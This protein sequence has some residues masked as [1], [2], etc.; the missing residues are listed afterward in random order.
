[1]PTLLRKVALLVGVALLGL[2]TFAATYYVAAT[3]ADT[4]N[5][6]SKATPWLH[7]PGMST[8]TSLCSSTTIN[9]GDSIIFRGGDTWHFGDNTQVPFAGFQ[10]N[11][12]AF[13]RSGSSTSCQLNAAAGA[14]VTTTCIYIG[15]DQTWFA[16]G[17]WTR[18]VFNF[19]NPVTTTSPASCTFDDTTLNPIHFNASY[20]IV[21]NLEIFGFCSNSTTTFSNLIAFSNGNLQWEWKNS[22][23]HGYMLGQTCTS[24]GGADCDEYWVFGGFT[25]ISSYYRIDH[26]VFDNSDGTYGGSGNKASLGVWN[27]GGMQF[28]HNVLNYVSNGLKF[29]AMLMV[30]DNLFNNIFEPVVGG[31]HGNIIEYAG[32]G[33]VYPLSTYYFNNLTLCSSGPSNIGESLDMYPGSSG[34][35]KVGYIFNNISNCNYGGG[36]GTNCYMIEGDGGNG[37]PGNTQFFNNTQDFQCMM[38]SLRGSSTGI[39]QNNHFV[40]YSPSGAIGNFSSMTVATDNGN[41]IWQTTGA[42]C[43]SVA[44]N[45]APTSNSCAT[46]GAGANLTST[47]CAGMDNATASA[48]CKNSYGGVTYNT[49]NH[50]AVDNS[51]VARPTSGSWDSGAYEFLPP[52]SGANGPCPGY[53]AYQGT[54][55]VQPPTTPNM[56]A[57]LNSGLVYRDSS[58]PSGIAPAV[59]RCTDQSIDPQTPF[60][61]QNKHAGLGGSGDAA[62][63]FAADDHLMG[64]GASGGKYYL[65][66][67]NTYTLICGD[68]TTGFAITANKN[69]TNP[70]SSGVAYNFGNGSF[71]WTNPLVYYAMGAGSDTTNAQITKYTFNSSD[72]FTVTSPYID[73]S[74]GIP[75]GA[76]APAWQATHA[77]SAGDYI[78]FTFAEPDWVASNAYSTLG[79]LIVPLLNNFYNCAFKLTTTGTSSISASEPIWSTSGQGGCVSA[80]QNV[81]NDNTAKWRNI[82][83]GPIF[84]YQ[85]IGSSGNSGGSTPAFSPN[86]FSA[87]ADAN[88]VNWENTG[89]TTSPAWSNPSGV[90]A[91]STRFAFGF[92]T[93][94]YGTTGS[95]TSYNGDQGTGVYAVAYSTTLNQFFLLNTATGWVSSTTCTGG[96]GYNC[97]G[98]TL[99]KLTGQGTV[100]AITSGPC[101]YFLHNVKGSS[102]LDYVTAAQNGLIPGSSG[103]CLGTGA[104]W[105][106]F[107]TFNS[108]TTLQSLPYGLNHWAMMDHTVFALTQHAGVLGGFSG[109]AYSDLLPLAN[110]NGTAVTSWQ[111]GYAGGSWVGTPLTLNCDI[112]GTWFPGDT[113]PT[114]SYG[115]AYDAHPGAQVTY[116]ATYSDITPVCG[117]IYNVATLAPPPVAA[118]QGEEVCISST[119]TWLFGAPI[120][121]WRTWRFTH[122]F[123][124]GGSSD[125]DVQFDISQ[126][127]GDGKYLAFTSDWMCTLGNTNGT[128]TGTLCAAPFVSGT[129]YAL[130][131]SVNP[132]SSTGGS[133]TNYNVWSVT[134]C[135]TG[136]IAATGTA[137]VVC[138]SGNVGTNLTDGNG[139]TVWTCQGVSNGKG[140]VF[141]VQLFAG[142]GSQ[143]NPPFL[144]PPGST[145]Q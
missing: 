137:W 99:S 40:G 118:Y 64:F 57:V 42:A 72:Q 43:G 26:N 106:P 52:C 37:G 81:I 112:N 49:S 98:G 87:A 36:T 24:S 128:T 34:S 30:D 25:S 100:T 59:V 39:Y 53:T 104:I 120:P 7:A 124:T 109:G 21:D 125:F 95:Y 92:S 68:P 14:I 33:Q 133:G 73:F 4:N 61:N 62:Q 108:T 5:G 50:T 17:S 90:S 135:G 66:H 76:Q 54:I 80:S 56:G 47:L 22:Y 46:V 113:N 134:S 12:W 84:T 75:L 114:C 103:S 96:S 110:P 105:Q 121:A 93:N 131:Q 119:P 130:G 140:D 55:I 19:D 139:Q 129:V 67:F 78:S 85:N 86:M 142:T 117:T 89:V 97:A 35:G 45:Y 15:V 77:Y 48:A 143:V 79:T 60:S 136:C 11:A 8:C 23:V 126:L 111:M 123:N 94:E 69:L 38:R 18:P 16:G 41:E 102:H 74:F 115:N 63:M 9:A 28:D 1:M 83:A 6:T 13:S 88:G 29:R 31:T 138:N 127:S 32:T 27:I 10:S 3:G 65:I 107:T 116:D 71:D 2:P 141:I 51:I 101:G 58:Y 20:V 144:L 122:N 44:T 132:F 82:G 145:I 91:D 70:G